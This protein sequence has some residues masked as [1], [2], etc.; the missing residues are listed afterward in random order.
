M[1][2][3]R[4]L[5]GV[6]L[7]VKVYFP[8]ASSTYFPSTKYKIAP[9]PFLRVEDVKGGSETLAA[10]ETSRSCRGFR[11][12]GRVYSI[13][14][15]RL[16]CCWRRIGFLNSSSALSDC[17][18]RFPGGLAMHLLRSGCVIRGNSGQDANPH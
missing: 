10:H 7:E 18:T 8:A 17:L 14:V 6:V 5:S 3:R 9:F 11:Q 15:T 2:V 16:C 12:N 1:T 13:S 4:I